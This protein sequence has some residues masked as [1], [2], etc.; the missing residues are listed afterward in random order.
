MA[1]HQRAPYQ[2]AEPQTNLNDDSDL[3]EEAL[4]ND[5]KQQVQFND[6]MSD[7]DRVNSSGAGGHAQDMQAQLA[8]AATPLEYQATLETKFASYDN[9]CSLFH[10][11]LNSDGPVDLDPPSVGY[12]QSSRKGFGSRV[13]VLLG[14]GCH[15]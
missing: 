1:L 7:L 10:F 13:I 11:I 6:D 15:R 14:M 4:A 5:Y 2:T 9:Y 8:A 3:E 12:M